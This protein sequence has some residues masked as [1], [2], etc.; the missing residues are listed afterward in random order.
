MLLVYVFEYS[1]VHIRVLVFEYS[2]VCVSTLA[3]VRSTLECDTLAT[4]EC[5]QVAREWH[6]RISICKPLTCLLPCG[7]FSWALL[8]QA[9][10]TLRIR[11]CLL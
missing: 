7:L 10:Q 2:R 11:L 3:Y 9:T 1:R 5:I 6:C 8:I 4:R